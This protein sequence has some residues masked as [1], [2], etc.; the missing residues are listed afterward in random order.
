M[1]DY[2]TVHPSAMTEVVRTFCTR[3]GSD[4][5]EAAL[6][7]ENLV[8]ANLSGHDSHGVGMI[9]QY[10][11]AVREKRLKVN[12]SAQIT[13]DSGALITVD[14]GM[15]YGQVMGHEAIEMAIHRTRAHGVC[16][17]SLRNSHHLGR[18][19][20]WGEQCA[21]AGLVSTHYVNVINR[22]PM[23]APFGGSDSRFAT[24]PY[25]AAVPGPDGEPVVLDMATSMIAMGKVRVAMNKGE[26]VGPD[27]LIDAAGNPTTDPRMM[28]AQPPG[29]VLAFGGHKGYGLAVIAELLAGALGGGGTVRDQN[30]REHTITNN[31]LSVLIDPARLDGAETWQAEVAAFTR[32]VKASPPRAG[33]D[34]VMVAGD[35]ERRARVAR[36]EGL[37]VDATTWQEV[38]AGG[39]SVGVSAAETCRIARVN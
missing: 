37:P 31:M 1:A 4:E 27:T 28:W 22:P 20:H 29:S 15:G 34:G 21:A 38:V 39:E 24:N 7:A 11:L 26:E 30:W 14:G 9:P 6:V 17:M 13:K 10:L 35:P 3:S 2:V 18:I 23:V 16:V 19:G 25:C 36:A 32:W 8:L 33:S 5:R 12:Q